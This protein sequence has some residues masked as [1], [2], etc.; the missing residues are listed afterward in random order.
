MDSFDAT[1]VP[2]FVTATNLN[3]GRKHVF[4]QG[5]V[6]EAVLASTAIPGVFSPVEIDGQTYID[7]GVVANL[8]LETAVLQGAKEILAIDLSHCFALPAPRNAFDVVTRTVDIVMRERVV[9]DMA[10]LGERANITLIQP[11]IDRGPGIGELRHVSKLIERGRE[12]GEQIA[13]RVFDLRGR[14]RPGVVSAD[15]LVPA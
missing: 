5:R 2:L 14:L 7:G 12:F 10:V 15:V 4:S 1:R 6:S 8:D 3:T 11:E 9:R 13:D